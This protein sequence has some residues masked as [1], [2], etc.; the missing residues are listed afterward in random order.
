MKKNILLIIALLVFSTGIYAQANFAKNSNKHANANHS[1]EQLSNCSP[2]TAML[3]SDFKLKKSPEKLMDKYSLQKLEEQ[4]YVSAFIKVNTDFESSIFDD[5]KIKV[6]S[7]VGDFYT[8]LVPIEVLEQTLS[9]NGIISLDIAQKALP[10][11][12]VARAQTWVDQVHSGTDLSQAYTGNGVVVGIIDGGFDYTHPTF[13]N[14]AYTQYRIS[15]IWEQTTSG[16]P[17]TGYT[18]GN[19]LIGQTAILNKANDGLDQ[20]SHG[21]HVASTAA[22]SGSALASTFKGMAYESEIVLVSAN[23]SNLGIADGL[24]Y[25]FDYAISQGKPAVVNMSL[26]THVGPHDGTSALDQYFD[27]VSGEGRILVGAAGNEGM[28]KLHLDYTFGEEET[29]FSFLEF[30][31]ASNKTNGSTYID[32]WGEAGKD[33]EIAI[34]LYDLE[35]G[36]YEDYTEYIST[37]TNSTVSYNLQDTDDSDTDVCSVTISVEHANA[38]N[39]KPHIY[40][41]FDNTDQDE[42]GD[43]FDYV[44]LEVIASN[45]KL[46]AWCSG[47]GEA[48]FAKKLSET[49]VIAGNTNLTVGEI[50]GTANSI[51]TAGAYTSK[52]TYKDFQDNNHLIPFYTEVGEIAPFSSLGPTVDGRTKPDITAPGN[53]I[54]AA[55]NSFDTE[56]TSTSAEVVANVN[57]GTDY[58]WFANMQGTSMASPMVT[59][60]VALWLEADPT[61]DYVR[62][63]QFMRANAFSD[64]YTSTVPNNTW[65]YGKIDAHETIKAIESV[66]NIEEYKLDNPIQIYPNPTDGNF[67]L[68]IRDKSFTKIEIIDILGKSIYSE[69]IAPEEFQKNYN[70]SHLNNGMY[71]I[72]LSNN[73]SSVQTKLLIAK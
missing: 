13:Y 27:A 59:G 40:L 60:I 50:G 58:W 38:L 42:T 39:D 33:F 22:G 7:Y 14:E 63:K 4:I 16:T 61:L 17:P 11:L 68:N 48:V 1:F 25:I 51:I 41:E 15:R 28:D 71:T 12:N 9:S 37:A 32:M 18:Y 43:V 21:T 23:Y 8:V 47:D 57:N 67:I 53:V 62:L 31:Y 73:T 72:R 66:T 55:V 45:T 26:G 29:I 2:F 24:A 69:S 52:N 10:K 65:G 35:A 34:N 56:Y 64:S 44:V 70:F 54:A 5:L 36:E 3:I 20:G 30:P 46:D 49:Y 19:E 6:N